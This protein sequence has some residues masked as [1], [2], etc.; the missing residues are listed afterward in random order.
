MLRKRYQIDN[1]EIEQ[2]IEDEKKNFEDKMDVNERRELYHKALSN[3]LFIL[4]GKAGS[5]KTTAVVNLIKWFKDH[6]KLPIYVF[7]PTG[8]A[9]LVIRKRLSDLGINVDDKNIRV[10]TIH[11]FLY[12]RLYE[13]IEF[14]SGEDRRNEI[15][16]LVDLISLILSGKWELF[17]ELETLAKRWRFTPKVVIIDESSMVDEVL[18][19]TLLCL[20]NPDELEHLILVGDEKQLPP[21]GVGRPL[22]DIIFYLKRRGLEINIIRLKSNL[23]FDPSKK[24][25]EL[26]ELFE[27]DEPL[28]P[29]QIQEILESTNDSSD[30]EIR[31]FSN[32]DELK[33][34]I[35]DILVQILKEESGKSSVN[36][37]S[38]FDLFAEI[39]E[40]EDKL[41]LDKVQILSPRRVGSYGT[42]SINRNVVLDGV[43]EFKPKTKL[44]CEENKYLTIKEG[45][46]DRK[47][48]GLAN[49]SIGYIRQK[50]RD[51]IYVEFDEF[52]ELIRRYGWRDDIYKFIRDIKDEIFLDY[53]PRTDRSIDLGYA[54]T[55]HKAQGSDFDYV[56]LVFPEISP[57]ITRELIYTGITRPRKK[58][59][60]L[61]HSDLKEDFP[62][63]L[64]KLHENSETERRKTLLFEYKRNPFKPYKLER[65][66]GEIIELK[67]KTEYIIAK[68][69]D[70]LGIEFEYEPEDFIRYRLY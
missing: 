52:E 68:T 60:L 47:I 4:T 56:I 39:F 35:R 16:R 64:S 31:Y 44:I 14:V 46:R 62:H 55:I 7:T 27:S 13:F 23:R 53:I 21:I 9:N 6:N 30:L 69:L 20:I 1:K 22:V 24:L 2:I 33:E 65:R 70:E 45:N 34:E 17:D 25:G 49:G 37:Q 51:K 66:N 28:I 15:F 10:S 12:G 67:S 18:L 57:F 63:I 36:V 26:S 50:K 38:I 3:G 11:R 32:I 5:G 43:I 58:L 48:L 59:Y 19:A 61:I 42:L 29:T 40:L 54:I 41:N 8:K